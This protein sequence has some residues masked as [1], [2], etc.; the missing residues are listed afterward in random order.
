[1]PLR[2]RGPA[3]Q[4]IKVGYPVRAARA[5]RRAIYGT[6]PTYHRLENVVKGWHDAARKPLA[7]KQLV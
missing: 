1:M 5:S 7:L 3:G 2:I 4:Q 6:H